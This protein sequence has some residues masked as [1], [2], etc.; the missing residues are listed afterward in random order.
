MS[1]EA[2][3]AEAEQLS[4]NLMRQPRMLDG[5]RRRPVAADYNIEVQM[6]HMDK[7]TQADDAARLELL[8]HEQGRRA[9][10]RQAAF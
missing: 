10:S 5:Y 2:L 9:A 3:R 6:K 4:G 1:D 7:L 8:T